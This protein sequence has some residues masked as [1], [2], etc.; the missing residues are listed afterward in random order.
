MLVPCKR[1]LQFIL[2]I[3]AMNVSAALAAPTCPINYGARADAKPNKLYLYFPDVT[4]NPGVDPAIFPPYGFD[5]DG[6]WLPLPA[7]DTSGLRA[8]SGTAAQLV[9]AVRDVVSDIYCEFNVQVITTRTPPPTTADRRNVIGIGPDLKDGRP[10]KHPQGP[11]FGQSNT[12]GGDPGDSRPMDFARIW[13]GSYNCSDIDLQLAGWANSIGGSAAHEAAHNYGLSHADGNEYLTTGED[14]FR[15]HLMKEGSKYRAAER[16]SPR[17]FSD[18]E[19]SVL[20]RQVGLAMDTMWTWDFINP[21]VEA[22]ATLRME[23]LSTQTDLILSWVF[24]GATSPWINPVLSGPSGTRT[25]KGTQYQ[26][27]QI[28]WSVGN[29]QWS[30]GPPGKVPQNKN[31]QIGGTF[32]P[33]GK[34]RRVCDPSLCGDPDAVI[35]SD[36]RLF[37]A[38]VQALP[39]RP[40]W[41]GFDAGTFDDGDLN[42]RFVNFHDRP[43]ILRDVVV[44]DLPRVMSIN[45]MMRNAPIRDIFGREFDAWKRAA[46][47]AQPTTIQPGEELAV[48]VAKRSQGRHVSV[49]RREGAC[50][51]TGAG[52]GLNCHAGITVDDLFPAT[53]MYITATVV[54]PAGLETR[55]FYQIAGRRAR[56]P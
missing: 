5:P 52:R 17:H 7:F 33:V 49:Q 48:A 56:V 36:V 35:I 42:I 24:A 2:F 4:V 51:G 9:D 20:A 40:H 39:Q 25:I 12:A 32:S 3:V 13:A 41:L 28:E 30:V 11:L 19:T 1:L 29:E 44:Q 31:F 54:D 10:C 46:P 50:R 14:D 37:D 55:L 22:A 21:N 26:V 23:L 43:L 27:Y 8:Y 15:H 16:A 6:K 47:L 45:A 38:N 53:T 18:F 34:D